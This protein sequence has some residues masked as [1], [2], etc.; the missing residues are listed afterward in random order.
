MDIEA[1]QE[2]TDSELLVRVKRLVQSERG[3]TAALVAH[4]AEIENRKL[5]VGEGCRSLFTYCTQV[6]HLS[7]HAA[8]NRIE[9]ARAARRFPLVVTGLERGDV[10]LTAVRLLAPLLTPE[11]HRD[12]LAAAKHKSKR[13]I[14]ELI[15]R[16]RPQPDVPASVRKMPAAR[17]AKAAAIK[18]AAKAVESPAQTAANAVESPA[19]ADAV[20][21]PGAGSV[22]APEDAPENPTIA[23][24]MP[25]SPSGCAVG[26]ASAAGLP[27]QPARPAQPVRPAAVVPLAPERYKVQFT[28]SAA[29]CDKL[30]RA[31]ELLRHQIPN[32]DLAAVVDLALDLLVENLEKKK[33][34]A[35]DRPR[36]SG[37]VALVPSRHIPAEVKRAV[38]QRDRGCCTFV[39]PNGEHCTERG[40][41][42]FDHIRPHGDGGRPTVDNVRLLCRRHN[43]YEAQQFFGPWQGE[44]ERDA[45]Q[46]ILGPG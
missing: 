42:E 27:P 21:A 13:E 6:L 46:R 8:Y 28:A 31:Q 39:S 4:L 34:G 11:N 9:A 44:G 24:A 16:L 37:A 41:L 30:R 12:L 38:W 19:T 23:T 26:Q 36:R 35:T 1:L 14:E 45:S 3:A 22:A 40:Q 7:E 10:H 29:T 33:F 43:Q 25:E 2:L 32:G 20:E 18:I 5:Y 17:T 15:V